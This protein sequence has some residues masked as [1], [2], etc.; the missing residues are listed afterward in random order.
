MML[1]SK[2]F[3]MV[4]IHASS[5]LSRFFHRSYNDV[6]YESIEPPLR[7]LYES[8]GIDADTYTEG[9]IIQGGGAYQTEQC[10][11]WIYRRV[12]GTEC[13]WQLEKTVD[14]YLVDELS[15]TFWTPGS[16]EIEKL[17]RRNQ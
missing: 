7:Y 8:K 2:L 4:K 5:I 14:D 9:L 15:P 6:E 3:N 1:L 10:I 12:P 17:P 16:F 11:L 13:W